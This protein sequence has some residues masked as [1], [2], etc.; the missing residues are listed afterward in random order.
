MHKQGQKD[1]AKAAFF[2]FAE[3]HENWWVETEQALNILPKNTAPNKNRRREMEEW[4]L[5]KQQQQ[6]KR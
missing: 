5:Y 4:N 6:V 3:M 1:G 2:E